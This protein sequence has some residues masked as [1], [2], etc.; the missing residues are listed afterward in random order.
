RPAGDS[1]RSPATEGG[2]PEIQGAGRER[3]EF[4]RPLA[5]LV[6]MGLAVP[7]PPALRVR[8]RRVRGAARP[9]SHDHRPA[10]TRPPA[11]GADAPRRSAGPAAGTARTFP[12]LRQGPGTGRGAARPPTAPPPPGFRI[13]GLQIG[14]ASW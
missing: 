2:F 3:A 9:R 14:R 6:P 11:Q 12:T 7:Q 10:R 5:G 1:P 13:A 8:T 4:F